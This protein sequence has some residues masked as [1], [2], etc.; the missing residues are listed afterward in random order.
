[1]TV[2]AW[3]SAGNVTLTWARSSATAPFQEVTVDVGKGRPT[4]ARRYEDGVILGNAAFER[5]R[6]VAGVP[7]PFKTVLTNLTTTCVV[8][9]KELDVNVEL[10]EEAF[11][12][13]TPPAAERVEYW[14][15]TGGGDAGYE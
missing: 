14:A 8:E 5:W 1:M 15:V 4:A 10:P 12:E 6:D 9:V 7:M 13:K 11:P 2:N 3:S